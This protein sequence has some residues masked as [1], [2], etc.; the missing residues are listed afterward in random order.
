MIYLEV[1]TQ[2]PEITFLLDKENFNLLKNHTWHSYK[3]KNIYYIRTNIKQKTK[4]R[5]KL[6]HQMI[7]PEFKMIDH[8]N[9]IGLDNR[10]INLRETTKRENGLNC[11]LF[12]HN[13]SGYNRICFYKYK[14]RKA[15]RFDWQE[16]KKYKTKKFYITKKRNSEQAKQLAIG[17]KLAHDEKTGNKNGYNV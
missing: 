9:R 11:K 14:N 17:F 8:I 16:N 5:T 4:F 6:L 13:T 12:S 2:K 1:K 3:D 15:W 7:K 10:E